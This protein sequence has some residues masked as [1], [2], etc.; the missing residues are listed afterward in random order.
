MRRA[1]QRSVRFDADVD[2]GTP[3]VAGEANFELDESGALRSLSALDTVVVASLE[4][5]VLE[6]ETRLNLQR[7]AS[8][9]I[10]AQPAP[11][12]EGWEV[13]DPLAPADTVDSARTLAR[14]FADGLTGFDIS[15]AVRSAGHGLP[16]ET[17]FMVR[18]VGRLRGWPDSADELVEIFDSSDALEARRL[19]FDILASAGT[20]QAQRV[21]WELQERDDVRSNPDFPNL[22]QRWAFVEHPTSESAAFLLELHRDAFDRDDDGTRTALL[23]PMGSMSRRIEV[24]DPLA[25]AALLETIRA[26]IEPEAH[27][28]RL[29]AAIAGLG[30]AGRSS[31]LSTLLAFTTRDDAQFRVSAAEALRFQGEPEAE[32]RLLEML[33]DENRFVAQ[34]ALAALGHIDRPNVPT[35]L[36]RA[37]LEHKVNPAIASSVASEIIAA[38]IDEDLTRTAVQTLASAST[39]PRQRAVMA[40]WLD[41]I[42][43]AQWARG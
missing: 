29:T 19:V 12:L 32:H 3:S 5:P 33:G 39:D 28:D 13:L 35:R 36:A 8:T 31:D 22:V 43:A 24:V 25:S 2:G 26:D 23:Y 11:N 18:A 37:A 17:G 14:N 4:E 30:N 9:R 6:S 42:A 10:D 41:Q 7:V 15:V 34:Q 20:P 38:E 1:L 21:M 40:S 16:P 27:R